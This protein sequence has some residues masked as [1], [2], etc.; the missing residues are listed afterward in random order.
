[1]LAN[2]T[3]SPAIFNDP[4]QRKQQ[5]SLLDL[6]AHFPPPPPPPGDRKPPP[7][8]SLEQIFGRHATHM[9]A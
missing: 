2:S 7:P 8:P 6:G 5:I 9:R 4:T 3:H 1:M